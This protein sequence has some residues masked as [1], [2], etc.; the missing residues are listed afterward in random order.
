MILSDAASLQ[1]TDVLLR[2]CPLVLAGAG[3]AH[4]V[5][6]RLWIEAGWQAPAGTVLISSSREAWY[7]GMMPGLIAGRFELHT[8]AIALLP[9]CERLGITLVQASVTALDSQQQRVALD[10]G[11][12]LHYQLLSINTGSQPKAPAQI[13]GSVSILPAKPFPEFIL[14]WQHWQTQAPGSVMVLGGGAAAFELGMALRQQFPACELSLA[15]SGDLLQSHGPALRTLALQWLARADIAVFEHSRVDAVMHQQ[16]FAGELPLRRIDAL[17]LATGA[18]A[19]PWYS[20][21]GLQCDS[22]G[23]INVDG[24]LRSSDARVF[25]AGDAASLAGSLRSGVYSVRHGPVL[26][27]NLRAAVSGH[28]MI[29]YKPQPNALAL[30]ATGNGGALM[31][32]GRFV[33]GG[34]LSAPLLGRWKDYLDQ[35]FMRR[36]RLLTQV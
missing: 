17:I 16:A 34:Q 25:A 6:M 23:F 32:Y 36:H 5:M 19:L 9:L 15:C 14:Q 26:A 11:E 21:S 22:Q 29:E 3:H 1:P 30:L 18:S 7:S 10:T 28:T 13:D 12:H 8:C 27:H 24:C 2:T 4:L 31:S 20:C 33:L 35:S